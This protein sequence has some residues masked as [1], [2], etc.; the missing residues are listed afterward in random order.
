VLGPCGQLQRPAQLPPSPGYQALAARSSQV[1]WR[2]AAPHQPPARAAPQVVDKDAGAVLDEVEA[3]L[4]QVALSILKGEGFAYDVP[5]RWA[6]CLCGA[7]AAPH[8]AC[9][10]RCACTRAAAPC[11]ATWCCHNMAGGCSDE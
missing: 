10:G 1:P 11:A 9:A 6:A 3:S 5:S 4:Y 8:A 7:C 2:R